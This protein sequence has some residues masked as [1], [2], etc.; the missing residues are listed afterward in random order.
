MIAHAVSPPEARLP[1]PFSLSLR[2]AAVDKAGPW[3]QEGYDEV[4]AL[5]LRSWGIADK[6]SH[7][8]LWVSGP[9]EQQVDLRR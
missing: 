5:P 1:R 6:L 9:T 7:P 2:P 4:P 3:N 8:S